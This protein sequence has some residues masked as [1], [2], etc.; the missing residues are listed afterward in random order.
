MTALEIP[1]AVVPAEALKPPIS[2]F[3]PASSSAATETEPDDPI[4]VPVPIEASV[5]LEIT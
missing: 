3:D 2:V 1:A 4:V 5:V